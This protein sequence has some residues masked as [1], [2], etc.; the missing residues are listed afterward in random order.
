MGLDLGVPPSPHSRSH[1]PVST[2]FPLAPSRNPSSVPLPLL[3]KG[4]RHVRDELSAAKKRSLKWGKYEDDM[5]LVRHTGPS[6]VLRG[7]ADL[8]WIRRIGRR[9]APR[10]RGARYHADAGRRCSALDKGA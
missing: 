6:G 7:S 9:R 3:A 5:Q 4:T 2:S 10:Y 8:H 1:F